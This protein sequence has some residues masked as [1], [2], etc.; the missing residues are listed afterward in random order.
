MYK[1]AFIFMLVFSTFL[2]DSLVYS[3]PIPGLFNTGKNSVGGLI[4]SNTQQPYYRY[5]FTTGS[6]GSPPSD[7]WVSDVNSSWANNN[8]TSKW[9]NWQSGTMG[10]NHDIFVYQLEFEIPAGYDP[11]TATIDL[12]VLA[13]DRLG[14]SGVNGL[15]LNTIEVPNSSSPYGIFGGGDWF[16]I[17]IPTNTAS[18]VS[19]TNQLNFTVTN[20]GGAVT[21]SPTGLRVEFLSSSVNLLPTPVPEPGTYLLM[22]SMM[23]LGLSFHM[24]KNRTSQKV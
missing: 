23:L 18:F 2:V 6:D 10:D 8:G 15:H 19:G 4:P 9:I 20:A 3:I 13:D 7:A 11:D 1:Y 22:G 16:S 5:I 14:E 12:R 17:T 21:R 24:Y